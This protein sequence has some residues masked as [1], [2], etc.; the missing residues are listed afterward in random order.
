MKGGLIQHTWKRWSSKTG[1][2]YWVI[3]NRFVLILRLISFVGVIGYM[4]ILL[5]LSSKQLTSIYEFPVQL[6]NGISIEYSVFI[7]PACILGAI[8][9]FTLVPETSLLATFS[10]TAFIKI[11][12][13]VLLTTIIF[14]DYLEGILNDD[15]LTKNQHVI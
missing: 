6:V 14:A 9:V 8:L 2:I 1:I 10:Y 11:I 15:T 12:I 3:K 5:N 7:Y 13:I 4:S